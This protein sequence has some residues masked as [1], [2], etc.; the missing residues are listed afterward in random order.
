MRNLVPPFSR[1]RKQLVWLIDPDKINAT[2]IEAAASYPDYI[3]VGGSY[4]SS[5]QLAGLC[6][7]INRSAFTPVVLFPADPSH[8][9]YEADAILFL[10]LVSGRNP[11]Y[12]IG[13]HVLAAP[14]IHRTGIPVISTAYLLID[15][16]KQTSASYISGTSPIPAD[17]PDIAAATALAAEMLGMSCIYL[18]MGSGAENPVSSTMIQAVKK[19]VNLPVIVGGGIRTP[20]A[21]HQVYKAGADVAVLGTILEKHPDSFPDF[22]ACR[23]QFNA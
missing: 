14:H 16:G 5:D 17:K 6:E 18:D 15:G 19:A 10:S 12:L 23:D 13:K 4:I 3:F 1:E 20:E 21:L 2:F 11:E 9:C 8:L 7:M 22:L